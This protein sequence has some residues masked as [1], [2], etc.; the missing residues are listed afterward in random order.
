MENL[1]IGMKFLKKGFFI[2]IK[3][4]ILKLKKKKD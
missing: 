2:F 1:L 3:K 4:N